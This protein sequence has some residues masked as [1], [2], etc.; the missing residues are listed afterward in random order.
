M[1]KSKH[2]R[3]AERIASKRGGK[4]PPKKGADVVN[5]REAIE[6]EVDPNRF[7]DGIRQLQG[8][9]KRRYLAVP[10]PLVPLAKKRLKGRKTGLMNENGQIVKPYG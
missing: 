6:V 1:A 4:Y 8:Y 2:D 3:I 5:A 9:G 7:S 10:N